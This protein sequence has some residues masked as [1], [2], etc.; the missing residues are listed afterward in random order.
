MSKDYIFP[1][2]LWK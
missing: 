2:K 1:D